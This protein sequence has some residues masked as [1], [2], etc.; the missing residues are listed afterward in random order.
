[1]SGRRGAW[2]PADPGRIRAFLDDL[3]GIGVD[4]GGG[5]SRLAFGPDERRAHEL[6]GEAMSGL[7]ARVHTDA[8][9]NTIAVVAGREDLPAFVTGSHLDS[10]M[11]GGNYDG[12]VGVAAAIETARVLAARGG[13]RH[14]LTVVAFA[15]EEGARFGA[16]C[17]GSRLL[18]G[19]YDVEALRALTDRDGVSALERAAESGL[20]PES[21][22]SARWD[23]DRVACFIEVHIEQ[24]KVLQEAGGLLGIVTVIGGSNRSRLTF[25]GIADHSGATPMRLRRDALAASSAFVLEVERRARLQSTAVATV[26]QLDMRPNSMTTV[27]GWVELAVDVRDIDAHVQTDLANALLAEARRIA[28]SRG[29]EV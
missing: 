9:G 20:H 25:R 29:V 24:G 17:I 19:A 27:P 4:P 16:P 23:F 2:A 26:G 6:F 13:L 22:A 3:A 18:T 10:V 21:A 7:G 1:M 15:A 11:H 8:V 14:P 28:R 12:G 5:W